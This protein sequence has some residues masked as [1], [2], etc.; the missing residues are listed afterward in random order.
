VDVGFFAVDSP[1]DS[2]MMIER[3][4]AGTP[5]RSH[6]T[7]PLARSSCSEEIVLNMMGNVAAAM[8]T[9]SWNPRSTALR[10]AGDSQASEPRELSSTKRA[11]R[12]TAP[13][14]HGD[15]S[16]RHGKCIGL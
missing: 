7:P 9:R 15:S 13:L 10:P 11:I 2:A 14:V 16:S 6:F 3:P 5:E 12:R 4:A 8:P 1:P